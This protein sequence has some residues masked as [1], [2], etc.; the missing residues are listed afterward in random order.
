[1]ANGGG[2]AGGG[3]THVHFNLSAI[4]GKSMKAMLDKHAPAIA[5]AVTSQVRN[6][7]RKVGQA[8]AGR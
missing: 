3:D 4:D 2:S 1:M 7:N 5:H 8:I 6:G